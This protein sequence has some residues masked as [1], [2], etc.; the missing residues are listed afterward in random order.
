[1]TLLVKASSRAED[2]QYGGAMQADLLF[3]SNT[4]AVLGAY[5][6]EAFKGVGTL[7]ADRRAAAVEEARKTGTPIGF[8]DYKSSEY[9][10]PGIGYFGGMTKE[11]AK[12]LA[13]NY[14]E[15]AARS[16]IISRASTGQ[17][18]AGFATA[19]GAGTLEPKNLG[20]GIATSLVLG[21]WGFAGPAAARTRALANMRRFG[22][23]YGALAGRGAVEGMVAA[24]A[25]EPSNRHSAS[26]LQQDYT[27]A[28]SLF[29]VAT[30]SLFGAA[31]NAAPAFIKDRFFNAP[32]KVKA[33]DTTLTELDAAT[34]QLT[35]GQ[36][37]DVGAVEA[38]DSLK[39][40]V[41][42]I[43]KL[44][45][46]EL[47]VD[48]VKEMRVQAAKSYYDSYLRGT[49][50]F[51]KDI[52][53][54]Q[55]TGSGWQ[56]FKRGLPTDEVKMQL[57][58]S[59]KSV[60]ENGEYRGRSPLDKP[61]NDNIVAFHYF[62]G[63]VQ[64]GEKIYDVGVSVAEDN[65]GN[66][67]YNANKDPDALLERKRLRSDLGKALGTEP[68][69]SNADNTI[70]KEA[71]DVNMD[72]RLVSNYPSVKAKEI[73][74]NSIRDA[75]DPL[76]DTAIDRNAIDTLDTLEKNMEA[77]DALRQ[78]EE[79][80]AE[81]DQL[82]K[83]GIATAKAELQEAMDGMNEADIDEAYKALYACLTRG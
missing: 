41:N 49:T 72:I 14:D 13:E 22:G 44:N 20:I 23:K 78:Y 34:Q 76:N 48:V 10:R 50:A 55:F 2:N 80:A 46:N 1:M 53:E 70:A 73:T 58:P 82:E 68:V 81:I 5:I 8:E 74:V 40:D 79:Y 17:N 61:R 75:A 28:D 47:G 36:R 35:Q 29:N 24:A 6:D 9:Y 56:K 43:A 54:V 67:F 42:P 27:M 64:I 31:F 45:G 63:P 19:L 52:G 62:Q 71:D 12:I 38:A 3:R 37:I 33:F 11:A 66:L 39:I 15:T 16:E 25:A 21:P 60:I 18:I 83:Q 26:I 57:L 77:Q 59:V 7:E 32:D 69:A 65:K 4:E 30:S 51:R